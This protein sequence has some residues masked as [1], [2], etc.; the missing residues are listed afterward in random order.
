MASPYSGTDTRWATRLAATSAR[1]AQASS[2]SGPHP[3][4]GIATATPTPSS[5]SV[6]TRGRRSRS[7]MS[8]N[9]SREAASGHSHVGRCSIRRGSI[10]PCH[11]PLRDELHSAWC[12]RVSG[13]VLMPGGQRLAAPDALAT[14]HRPLAGHR[15]HAMAIHALNLVGLA[16]LT[17][18]RP[19]A[20]HTPALGDEEARGDRDDAAQRGQTLLLA[21]HGS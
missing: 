4:Y 6:P 8:S 14:Q 16:A 15:V 19:R 5:P 3:R 18:P 1:I 21:R 9:R 17:L 2:P 13:S 10:T 12:A 7:S 20:A 11:R